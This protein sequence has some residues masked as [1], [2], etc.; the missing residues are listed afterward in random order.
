MPTLFA[1]YNAKDAKVTN[2]YEAYTVERP[3]S[4]APAR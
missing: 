1:V 2:D 3:G 4:S